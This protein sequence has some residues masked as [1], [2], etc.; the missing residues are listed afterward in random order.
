MPINWPDVIVMGWDFWVSW[1][2]WASWEWELCVGY[3][4]N[5]SVLYFE[6][7]AEWY[8]ATCV[9]VCVWGILNLET[10]CHGNIVITC[11]N[12]TIVPL[13]SSLTT[14]NSSP[15][16]KFVCVFVSVC[17]LVCLIQRD[18]GVQ[19]FCMCLCQSNLVS[20]SPSHNR[21]LSLNS[22]GSILTDE[23]SREG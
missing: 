20:P 7:C 15:I 13:L 17:L 3:Y 16:T 1:N 21:N 23:A 8:Q 19:E 2:W 11:T 14:K 10:C 18:R 12:H 22:R 9:Y 6:E 5:E 4:G